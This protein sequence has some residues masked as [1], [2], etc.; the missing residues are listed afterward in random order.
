MDIQKHMD[1]HK[2]GSTILDEAWG[3]VDKNKVSVPAQWLVQIGWTWE[4]VSKVLGTWDDKLS[5][6]LEKGSI[7]LIQ[8]LVKLWVVDRIEKKGICSRKTT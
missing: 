5:E 3:V 6:S 8:G 2:G 4:R 7:W 1:W